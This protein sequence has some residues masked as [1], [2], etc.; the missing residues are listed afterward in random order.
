[1]MVISGL[2]EARFEYVGMNV[3]FLLKPLHPEH[4]L[5]HVQHLLRSGGPAS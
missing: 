2:D 3:Q 1:V 5:E 4:L